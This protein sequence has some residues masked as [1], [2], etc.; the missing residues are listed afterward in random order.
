MPDTTI[1]VA[2]LPKA[3]GLSNFVVLCPNG[4]PNKLIARQPPEI[5]LHCCPNKTDAIDLDTVLFQ[6]M[7]P[8]VV[9]DSRQ[10]LNFLPAFIAYL[11]LA[12]HINNL[13]T[14]KCFSGPTKTAF[15]TPNV[16]C[17]NNDISLNLRWREIFNHQ[18]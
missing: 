18:M 5:R 6:N 1:A 4:S 11:G 8:E 16:P 3:L 10:L 2:E 15:C 17:K 12:K 7:K 13:A 14:G 9:S